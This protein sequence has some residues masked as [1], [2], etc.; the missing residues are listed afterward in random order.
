MNA[1]PPPDL[2]R[3]YEEFR[4]RVRAWVVKLLGRDEAD[5]VVQEVFIKVRRALPDLT[6][7]AKLTAWI[8]AITLNTVR[9]AVRRRASRAQLA[10][11]APGPEAGRGDDPL[12]GIPDCSC[13]SPEE[14]ALRS[15]MIECYL[16]Y[17]DQLPP[18]YR[19]VYVLSEI[20]QLSNDEIARRLSLSVGA[21]KIR[22]H[23]ARA[24]LFEVLR[25]D[26]QCYANEH[27]DL[28]GTRR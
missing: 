2:P 27:G 17:V 6:D 14:R 23:R 5:D 13:R 7:T 9:D 11:V 16:A 21:V 15:E 22:L 3:I 4:P 20:E 26:C 8:H 12:G 25:R 24:R 18:S 19:G 1:T 10:I 28:M